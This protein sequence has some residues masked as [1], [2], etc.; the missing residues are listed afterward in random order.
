MGIC[1]HRDLSFAEFEGPKRGECAVRI[2]PPALRG[3]E[4]GEVRRVER[5]RRYACKA[6]RSFKQATGPR[7]EPVANAV[8]QRVDQL[9]AQLYAVR[10]AA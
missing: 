2:A 8:F 1:P 4:R 5:R 9:C 3:C 7:V 6:G 10:M